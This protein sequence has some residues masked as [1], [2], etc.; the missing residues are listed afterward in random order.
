MYYALKVIW[1]D[2][3]T[4]SC[5]CSSSLI[6][7]SA[8]VRSHYLPSFA[9]LPIGQPSFFPLSVSFSG[10]APSSSRADDLKRFRMLKVFGERGTAETTNVCTRGTNR[11]REQSKNAMSLTHSCEY[12]PRRLE[13]CACGLRYSVASDCST[14]ALESESNQRIL[15]T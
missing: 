4:A 14:A 7:T 12:L 11:A 8:L 2:N 13:S 9:P 6:A 10:E 1:E 3:K 5:P 15:H